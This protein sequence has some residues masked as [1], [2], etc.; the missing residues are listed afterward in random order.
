MMITE[1]GQ[2]T[3]PNEIRKQF[4]LFPH[5]EVEFV[6]DHHQVVLKKAKK[7]TPKRK[8]KSPFNKIIGL[9]ETTLTT[10]EIMAL[11]RGEN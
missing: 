2:V 7:E 3:I 8:T 5:T 4:G 11:T 10:E 6:V 1:K 9:A